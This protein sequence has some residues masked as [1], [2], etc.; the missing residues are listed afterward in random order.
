MKLRT[1]MFGA[2][3]TY[4][5]CYVVVIIIVPTF[6]VVSDI[7]Q[8]ANQLHSLIV[9][10]HRRLVR[11]QEVLV[12]DI[13]QRMRSN[14]NAILFTVYNTGEFAHNLRKKGEAQWESAA[15]LAELN[16]SIGFVQL[17]DTREN[18]TVVLT[19]SEAPLFQLRSSQIKE[20]VIALLTGSPEDGA[21]QL[22]LGAE[23]P[24]DFQNQGD[25]TYYAILQWDEALKQLSEINKEIKA[26]GKNLEKDIHF[27]PQQVF[28]TPE[29]RE[30]SAEQWLYKMDM[31]RLLTPLSVEGITLFGDKKWVP[32]GIARIKDEG[33]GSAIFAS[34]VF[35]T[36]PLTDPVKYYES[37]PPMKY[38]PPIG[39]G[40]F[41]VS[42][43]NL[44]HVYLANTLDLGGF[45]V[46][47]GT[48]IDEIAQQFAVWADKPVL[49]TLNGAL[50]MGFDGEG[51]RYSAKRLE[52]Y[53]KSEIFS[54][55]SGQ[56]THEDKDF[57]F[58]NIAE[59]EEGA[60]GIYELSQ[61]DGKDSIASLSTN[62]AHQLAWKI[63]FQLFLLSLVIMAILL[64]IA[65]RVA[66]VITIRPVIALAKATDQIVA[67]QYEQIEWPD[68]GKRKDEIADLTHSFEQMVT[69][70]REKEKIRGV[71]DKVVSKDVAN[72]ILKS[73]IHLGG[74]ERIV[75]VLFSDI[76][77]FSQM[78]ENMSPQKTIELLNSCM[79]KLT[80]V[81]EGEGGVIDKFVGDAIMAIYGAP[82][83]CEDHALRA[84]SA[85]VLIVRALKNWNDEREQRGEQRVEMGIGINT[86]VVVAGNMGAI[87]RL[88]YTVLGRNVN[89]SA[90]LCSVAKPQQLVISEQTLNEPGV[91]ESFYVEALPSVMLKGFSEP[92]RIYHVIDFKWEKE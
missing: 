46:T 32:I 70:L 82:T 35:S 36:K 87:D 57:F 7:Q 16:P 80:Q 88:N 84:V 54:K 63:S 83:K 12:E 76:R 38:A 28:A 29:N 4:F 17:S 39:Q 72:E 1:K 43:P 75:S 11:D 37:N 66:L 22:Y 58:A 6:V 47:L 67:G 9:E 27:D 10:K 45:F 48:P 64:F 69:G 42:A 34:Q 41:Y 33:E 3:L 61:L 81:I 85:G 49:V 90:R 50:I 26:A 51:K 15:K 44:H 23:L 71:L 56:F 30:K 73:Q 31:I 18:D 53:K 60:V 77:K 65:G 21:R 40:N 91:K 59:F 19:P 92:F 78:T 79:T 74:E 52:S 55:E 62:V 8:V 68:V 5:V 20:G 89:I 24:K 14:I 2:L 25:Y 13:F 86:G